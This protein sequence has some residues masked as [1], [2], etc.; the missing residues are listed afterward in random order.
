MIHRNVTPLILAFALGC[1]GS[2]VHAQTVVSDVGQWP[3]SQASAKAPLAARAAARANA[4]SITSFGSSSA[5]HI[6]TPSAVS[7]SHLAAPGTSAFHKPRR[8]VTIIIG[9]NSQPIYVPSHNYP[10]YPAY[11]TYPAYPNTGYGYSSSNYGSSVSISTPGFQDPNYR[12]FP[13]TTTVTTWGSN[14]NYGHCA[15]Q[16]PQYNSYPSYPAYPTYVP[17]PAINGYRG[18]AGHGG[19]NY[20]GGSMVGGGYIGNNSIAPPYIG[21]VRTR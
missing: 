7:A 18:A 3:A 8:N 2:A 5:T 10:S 19:Y 21:S 1:A 12:L 20:N 14:P 11:P 6:T 4:Q 9:D 17:G 15:P 16:Y 13:W